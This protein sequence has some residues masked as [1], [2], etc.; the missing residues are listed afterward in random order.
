MG[1]GLSADCERRNMEF[2]AFFGVV[3]KRYNA[4]L[5]KS[6]MRKTYG[7][8]ILSIIGDKDTGELRQQ[9]LNDIIYII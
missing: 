2:G 5:I 8:K 4:V 6:A 1:G 3:F 7:T 9:V